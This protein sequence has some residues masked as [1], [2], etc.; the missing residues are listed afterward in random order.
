[1]SN[2]INCVWIG[3]KLSLMEKLSI[4]L[5]QKMGYNVILWSNSNFDDLPKGVELKSI[6]TDILAPVGF[7]GNPHPNLP[8]GGIGSLSHWSD[9]FAFNILYRYGGSWMQLDLAMV[10][11]IEITKPYAFIAWSDSLSPIFMKIPKNS[12]YA[13]QM[14]TELEGPIKNQLKGLQWEYSLQLMG[15]IAKNNNIYDDCQR[16]KQPEDGYLD[17]GGGSFCAY[18]YPVKFHYSWIHWSNATHNTNKDN[19]KV[20]SEYYK[21]CKINNLIS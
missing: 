5:A 16:I 10:N 20:D 2:D 12:E 4:I 8:N 3:S 13:K 6:P 21:L 17:C 18:Y 9:Y 7:N 19:P 11:K 15:K 14:I 1:M